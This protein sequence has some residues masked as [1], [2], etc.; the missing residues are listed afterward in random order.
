MRRP[1]RPTWGR[2]HRRAAQAG[3]TSARAPRFRGQSVVEFALVSLLLMTM[4]AGVV[5]LGRGVYARTTLTNAVREAARYG[6][7]DPS[8]SAGIIAAAQKTSPGLNL[9]GTKNDPNPATLPQEFA[10]SGGTIRCTDRN[11]AW[12]PPVT[13]PEGVAAPAG[14]ALGVVGPA[15]AA[16]SV[17]AETYDCVSRYSFTV[18]GTPVGQTLEGKVRA[19][20]KVRVIFDVAANCSNV[21][22]SLTSWSRD[23]KGVKILPPFQTSGGTFN[24]GRNY[25]LEVQVPLTDFAVEFVISAYV[26]IT[27][28]PVPTSTATPTNTPVPTATPTAT[29]TSTPTNTATP[30]PTNTPTATATN[31]P[32]PTS[33]ST[34]TKT[35]TPGPTNTPTST[36]TPTN[37]PLP[38]STPTKTAT[39]T[40][41]PIPT[42]TPTN[43]PTA[44]ATSTPTKTATPVPTN[45]PTA[46]PVPPPAAT[47]ADVTGCPKSDSVTLTNIPSKYKAV[48]GYYDTSLSND[49]WRYTPEVAPVNG[50]AVITFDYPSYAPGTTFTV[51]MTLGGRD[52]TDGSIDQF[53]T[54]SWTVRCPAPTSTPTA[55]ATATNTPPPTNTPTATATPPPTSTPTATA[56][57]TNTPLPTNT[58]MP[59]NTPTATATP[60]NTAT[61]LPT[62]T[63]TITPTPT[64]TATPTKTATPTNTPTAT[65]IV[66][67][68]PIEWSG[69]N[70][71]GADGKFIPQDCENPQTGN[72]LTVCAR[73]TFE[74]ALP[75]LIGF[76]SIPMRE[77]ASVDI[78]NIQ[79]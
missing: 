1:T 11:F 76:G 46:T 26:V 22:A 58:P 21:S 14:L 9:V 35:A 48:G 38:T 34:P 52:S 74:L 20:D 66:G 64:N 8:N 13:Q 59:T 78:Q 55:T 32:I 33:T 42:S 36:V 72:L 79:R 37:T 62:N 54:I 4:V 73:Y 57:A 47:H 24:A 61:P 31:T 68:L 69:Q 6:A 63:P 67:G 70:K 15:L 60:T 65:P 49:T 2:P 17:A 28:T 12:M 3:V 50:K 51:T 71:V 10:N 77:C 45:T 53:M 25:Y 29:A 75:K 41:T 5:D 23:D 16:R 40:N 43:T 18:N 30:L 7:T 19:G 44:T 39:P 56:T 27:P